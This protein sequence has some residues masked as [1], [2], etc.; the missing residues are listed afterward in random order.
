MRV[1]QLVKGWLLAGLLLMSLAGAN[2]GIAQQK[3]CTRPDE[4]GALIVVDQL[5]SWKAIYRAFE[6]FGHCD[7]GA[8]AEGFS[9]AVVSTL[10]N[11]GGRLSGI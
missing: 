10:A 11:P 6:R 7:D 5:R 1:L 3:P 2:N 4:K 8:I 9:D